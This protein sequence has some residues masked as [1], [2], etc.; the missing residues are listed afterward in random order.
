MENNFNYLEISEALH[1]FKI[2]FNE[3]END[4]TDI[5]QMIQDYYMNV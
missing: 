1:E 3:V 4:S 5:T 2:D